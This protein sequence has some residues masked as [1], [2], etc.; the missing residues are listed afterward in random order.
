[1]VGFR[2]SQAHGV[3][4]AKSPEFRRLTRDEARRKGVSYSSKHQVAKH[5]KR[6]TK[7]TKTY[8]NRKAAELRTKTK[9]EAYTK[10][11]FETKALK[12][13]GV[14]RVYKNL[15]KADL[16]KRLKHERPDTEAILY[17]EGNRAGANYEKAKGKVWSSVS[18]TTVSNINGEPSYFDRL[19]KRA[20]ITDAKKFALILRTGN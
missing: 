14:S 20:N 15:S 8:T 6:V 9:R 19:L 3:V 18:L 10:S 1:M 13:G 4:M 5:I 16:F 7:R 11:R 12:K 17:A 2:A